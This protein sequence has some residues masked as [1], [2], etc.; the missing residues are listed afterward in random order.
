M[1]FML[2][3]KNKY[4]GNSRLDRFLLVLAGTLFFCVSAPAFAKKSFS[5]IKF[6]YKLN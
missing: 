2:F 5:I 4:H 1:F 3:K 6:F